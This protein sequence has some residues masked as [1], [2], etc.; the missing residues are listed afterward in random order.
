[1]EFSREQGRFTLTDRLGASEL[2]HPAAHNEGRVVDEAGVRHV[3]ALVQ[4]FDEAAEPLEQGD[5]PRVLLLQEVTIEWLRP[6]RCGVVAPGRRRPHGDSAQSARHGGH[7]VR[8][9]ACGR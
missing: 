1:M 5:E 6:V 2:D 3:D 9:L 4:Q 8:D 7:A